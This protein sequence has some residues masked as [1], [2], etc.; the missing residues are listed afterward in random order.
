MLPQMVMIREDQNAMVQPDSRRV[1]L[2]RPH[3]Q[4]IVVLTPPRDILNRRE[5]TPHP[6]KAPPRESGLKRL[7][8]DVALGTLMAIPVA[9]IAPTAAGFGAI[10]GVAAGGAALWS[11]VSQLSGKDW[12]ADALLGAGMGAA[13][14]GF[15]NSI[16]EKL[17]A[18]CKSGAAEIKALGSVAQKLPGW[19]KAATIVADAVFMVG[20]GSLMRK[21]TG[22]PPGPGHG[23]PQ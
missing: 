5:Q 19:A 6:P 21:L 22:T 20:L 1:M 2:Q 14:M 12:L 17:P 15:L 23:A 10:V 9:F 18:W 8:K 7:A 16:A 3:T 13:G 4:R 11:A